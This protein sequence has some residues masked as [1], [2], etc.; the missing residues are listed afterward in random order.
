M[1]LGGA[2]KANGGRGLWRGLKMRSAR[3]G[4][5]RIRTYARGKA[6]KETRRWGDGEMGRCARAVEQSSG[7]EW[8]K[9]GAV[10]P[11]EGWSGGR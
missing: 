10:K 8:M 11:R 9:R 5:A 7:S 6:D 2:A 3:A 1:V 4:E